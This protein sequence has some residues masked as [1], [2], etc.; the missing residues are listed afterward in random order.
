MAPPFTTLLTVAAVLASRVLAQTTV[1]T[2][3]TV[4]VYNANISIFASAVTAD[5][6][7]TQLVLA[8]P[9][10]A[11]CFFPPENTLRY[12]PKT[13]EHNWT[14][15][16]SEEQPARTMYDQITCYVTLGKHH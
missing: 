2:N 9:T 7:A 1:L 12:G 5:A 10:P 4:P 16:M 13:A 15:T 3:L 8:C 6:T 11:S 14:S